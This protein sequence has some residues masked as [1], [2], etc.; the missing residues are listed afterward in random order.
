M[1]HL[2]Y[3][4]TANAYT[5]SGA[6]PTWSVLTRSSNACAAPGSTPLTATKRQNR[7]HDA[8]DR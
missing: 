3:T 2:S 5:P 4:G 1:L 6:N 8:P 7:L